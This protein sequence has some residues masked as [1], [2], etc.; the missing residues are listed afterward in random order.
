MFTGS[1]TPIPPSTHIYE[2]EEKQNSTLKINTLNKFKLSSYTHP[3]ETSSNEHLSLLCSPHSDVCPSPTTCPPPHSID[4]STIEYIAHI[5]N[6]LK[7]YKL[8]CQQTIKQ[9]N[10]LHTI[11]TLQQRLLSSSST[12]NTNQHSNMHSSM[13]SRNSSTPNSRPTS[14]PNSSYSGHSRDRAHGHGT[15]RL[16]AGT[17]YRVHGSESS[18]VTNASCRDHSGAHAFETS[19]AQ[20]QYYQVHE[21]KFVR[22]IHD[23]HHQHEHELSHQHSH[24]HEHNNEH[25]SP[26]PHS[27]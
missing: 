27:I 15:A 17:R 24:S 10:D 14:R 16:S 1:H 9:Y 20:Q 7:K 13:S 4:D 11:Y 21:T 25:A 19:L 18:P 2:Q 23:H 12:S 8:K 5:E 22:S 26:T 6:D 3:N